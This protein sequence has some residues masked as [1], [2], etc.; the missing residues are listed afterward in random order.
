MTTNLAPLSGNLP[1]NP[2]GLGG[3]GHSP[4]TGASGGPRTSPLVRYLGAIRRFKWLVL[5][6]SLVGLGGGLLVS[7]L[8]PESFNVTAD[9]L[10]A[11]APSSTG[12]I[13]GGPA[14]QAEQWKELFTNPVVLEP[15]AISRRHYIIGPK[16]VGAPPLPNGPSGP[17]AE[18]FGNFDINPAR[19]LPGLYDFK[20]NDKG[21]HWDLVNNR[22]SRKF[23]GVTGDSAG[24]EFGFVWVPRLE[25]RW[26]GRTF[27]FEI[28]TPREA[29][30]AIKD[31]MEVKMAPRAA[32]FMHVSLSGQDAY[33]T[34]A[35]L[36][37]LVSV[38]VEK[39]GSMKKSGLTTQ[40]AI[41][42]TQLTSAQLRLAAAEGNLQRFRVNTITLP[43]EDLPMAPG[44]AQS[45]PSATAAFV[46]KRRHVEELRRDRRDLSEALDRAEAGDL[47][48]DLFTAIPTVQASPAL[49]GVIKELETSESLLRQYRKT[50]TD[51]YVDAKISVPKLIAQI[52]E[53]RNLTIPR[54]TR[55][56]MLRLDEN[57]LRLDNEIKASGRELQDIPNRT[58]AE[59]RYQ[60]EIEV[61]DKIYKTLNDR[62]E[63]ARLIEAS[64]LA[65]VSVLSRAVAPARP[66]K[67]R[68]I[69]IVAAGVLLG[70]AAGLGLAMLF[71]VTDKRV[72]YADQITSGL[73]LTILGVIPE[74]KRAKG[75]TA[76][77]EEAAQ[78]IEAFRTVRLNLAHTVGEGSLVLTITSPSPG[79][80]KS[81]VSSNLALS[82]AEAGYKT[83]LIDGDTRRGELHRTFG[84]ERRPG[85]LDF[86][87]GELKLTELEHATQHPQLRLITAG[88]RKRNAPELL[89]GKAMRDLITT[90][91]DKYEVVIVDSPPL[92]A[93]IDPFVLSTL[94]G[95]MLLVLRAGATERDLAEA[96]LQ[97]VDQL[98]IRLIG[99]VL[100]D[101]RATMDG[102]K[103]YS[104]SYGYGAVEE[105]DEVGQLAGKPQLKSGE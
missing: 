76:S 18:L 56:V 12:A 83:V 38:F 73:G 17:D 24:R 25:N 23:S 19:L 5:L 6:L 85:L 69:F 82:F 27:S 49:L 58:I 66:T 72:R 39:A 13:Q 1:V 15:V 91:R 87:A 99:A 10:I 104:Y 16:R 101:V 4:L 30:D 98:P 90:M 84:V 64:S 95:N 9:I 26:F 103:Y 97:I 74:I 51:D 36:N 44:L 80:G 29:A 94:T 7:R 53:I 47:A 3:G 54:Y 68:K 21:D 81:L 75:E 33:E 86:L 2:A 92:G 55:A 14:Y 105:G 45:T 57:I 77:P 60:R 89:G 88:S 43:K 11:D 40:A 28:I 93:G 34:A 20:V 31:R 67:N 61:A 78:V 102:Y 37:D 63:S 62:Y 50:Y 96:K 100:N 65:D 48:V 71:D 41:L 8:R 32:R 70:L 46:E 42:D 52:Q 35:T 79:D 22:T 59:N